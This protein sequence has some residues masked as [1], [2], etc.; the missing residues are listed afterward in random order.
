[1]DYGIFNVRTD[2][3]AC[4]CTRGRKDSVRESVLKVDS[5]RKIPCRTGESN[6]R[7]RRA[8]PMLYQLSYIPT[9]FRGKK[10]VQFWSWQQWIPVYI[11]CHSKNANNEE[12][13]CETE[14]KI[15]N[16]NGFPF[17]SSVTQRMRTMKRTGV[18]L[19]VKLIMRGLVGANIMGSVV[20]GVE[21][22]FPW[23]AGHNFFP[24]SGR[25][26]H[27]QTYYLHPLI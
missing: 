7:R 9:P 14:C 1:M 10:G 19:S 21:Q 5:G 16:N 18:R 26:L 13:W 23:Q 17:I 12:N 4:D 6:L 8:G 22:T 11:V 2:V 24:N 3:N 20:S 25:S 27:L 15:D